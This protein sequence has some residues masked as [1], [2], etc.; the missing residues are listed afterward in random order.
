ML[1]LADTFTALITLLKQIKRFDIEADYVLLRFKQP[2][3]LSVEEYR[4]L[5]VARGTGEDEV[6]RELGKWREDE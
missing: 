5:L 4:A 1:N 6:I 2:V 3:K